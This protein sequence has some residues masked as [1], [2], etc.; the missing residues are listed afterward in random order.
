MT[1][2]PDTSPIPAS[3]VDPQAAGVPGTL[4][5]CARCLYD[6][7]TPSIR[8]DEAGVCNYCQIHDELDQQYPIGDEG[9]ARLQ[10]IAND[11][12]R[13]SRRRKYDVVVGVSGGCDSS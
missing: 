12:R 3:A 6:E 13:G 7:Q 10:Q 5:R 2:I 11:I 4:R 9:E 8:F 1:T